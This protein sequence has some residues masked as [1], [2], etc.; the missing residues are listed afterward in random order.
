LSA[1]EFFRH[2]M[3]SKRSADSGEAEVPVGRPDITN[4][5]KKAEPSPNNKATTHSGFP[6]RPGKAKHLIEDE[7]K[8]RT[9]AEEALPNVAD[10]ASALF[11]WLKEAHPTVPRPTKRTIENNIRADHRRWQARREAGRP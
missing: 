5:A 11:D 6:G 10:E 4:A 9:K 2:F 3:P 8:R 1:A 7:F